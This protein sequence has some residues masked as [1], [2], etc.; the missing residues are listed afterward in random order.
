[1]S[2]ARD[3]EGCSQVNRERSTKR[4]RKMSTRVRLKNKGSGGCREKKQKRKVS[5]GRERVKDIVMTVMEKD[6]ERLFFFVCFYLVS[7]CLCYTWPLL[8]YWLCIIMYGFTVFG[9]D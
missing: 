7:I 8:K 4:E 9:C 6:G 1:M 2:R 5:R 3:K